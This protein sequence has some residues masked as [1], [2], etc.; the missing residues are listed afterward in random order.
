MVPILENSKQAPQ[1][2]FYQWV[3]FMMVVQAALFYLPYKV[4]VNVDCRGKHICKSSKNAINMQ[5][6]WR[7]AID[8]LA[9]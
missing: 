1:T 5:V 7:I 6:Q 8:G 3:T 2:S 4:G 9:L